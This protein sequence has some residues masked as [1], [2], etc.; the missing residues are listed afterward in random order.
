M[1]LGQLIEAR[2]HVLSNGTVLLFGAAAY[3]NAACNLAIDKQRIAARD[4]GNSRI[5]GLDGQSICD[6]E[7]CPAQKSKIH[8]GM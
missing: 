3:A 6:S 7:Y 2:N 1:L 8:D 5:A 4:Q